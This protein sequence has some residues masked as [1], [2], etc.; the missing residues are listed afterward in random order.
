M[1]F[2]TPVRAASLLGTGIRIVPPSTILRTVGGSARKVGTTCMLD[3]LE[4]LKAMGDCV[5]ASARKKIVELSVGRPMVD[6]SNGVRRSS[7]HRVKLKLDFE[8]VSGESGGEVQNRDA[9]V[10]PRH[11]ARRP[12]LR[13][14]IK[15]RRNS[16][17]EP[18][19][20]SARNGSLGVWIWVVAYGEQLCGGK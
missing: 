18:R 6:A 20:P 9:R 1:A 13:V 15:E 16:R 3:E 14:F 11:S 7:S 17:A 8:N 4:A 10:G 2:E 5:C 19:R 12:G